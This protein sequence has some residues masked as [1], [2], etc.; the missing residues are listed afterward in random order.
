MINLNVKCSKILRVSN[1]CKLIIAL[2][3]STQ[4]KSQLNTMSKIWQ[5]VFNSQLVL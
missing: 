1:L 4:Y 3:T 2:V 5:S